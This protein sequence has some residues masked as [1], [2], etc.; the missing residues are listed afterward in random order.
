MIYIVLWF[1]YD[2]L[3]LKNDVN[4]AFKK[5]RN[6]QK[7][8]AKKN[9]FCWYLEGHWWRKERDPDPQVSG[10]D[11][12]IRIRTKTSWIHNIGIRSSLFLK[13]FVGGIFFFLF[14]QYLALLHLPPPLCRRMLGSNPGP[15]Q[16][17]HWQSN[18]LT[19]RLDLIR[20]RLDLI[21]PRLELIRRSLLRWLN[22]NKI[23]L[24]KNLEAVKK[25][26]Q[27]IW[28]AEPRPYCCDDRGRGERRRGG[29][30]RWRGYRHGTRRHWRLQR[31][32][33]YLPVVVTFRVVSS[34][35]RRRVEDTS[36]CRSGRP[37]PTC[38]RSWCSRY[39]ID[40]I[41]LRKSFWVHSIGS[42]KSPFQFTITYHCKKQS[43]CIQKYFC[44]Y[45][46]HVPN[47]YND[48][49]P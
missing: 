2:F 1:L 31:S 19:T 9:I 29:E 13:T 15:L 3:S 10:T 17:V 30:E 42:P 26:R 12:R 32:G 21:C 46:S 41:L 37:S 34:P 8:F 27:N 38:S 47:I 35:P 18:A 36:V 14:V 44:L 24:R 4:G 43:V 5:Y 28:C 16:L 39:G 6:K 40:T 45:S 7:N 33:K 49:K 25:F 23:I 11:P 48:T 22:W 20:T